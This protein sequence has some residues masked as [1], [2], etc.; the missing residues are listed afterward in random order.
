MLERPVEGSAYAD[1]LT[2]LS[3]LEALRQVGAA[4][5]RLWLMEATGGGDDCLRLAEASQAVHRALIVLAP[6]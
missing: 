3:V 2:K 1:Y 6:S 5:D 4:L